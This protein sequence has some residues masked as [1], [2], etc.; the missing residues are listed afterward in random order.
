M[1]LPDQPPPKMAFPLALEYARR[2]FFIRPLAWTGEGEAHA[3]AWLHY[4]YGWP[5][6]YYWD[7]SGDFPGRPWEAGDLTRADWLAYWTALPPSCFTDADLKVCECSGDDLNLEFG[8]VTWD[9]SPNP[10]DS[11]DNPN[12]M[13]GLGDCGQPCE[14]APKPV[15]AGTN[16]SGTGSPSSGSGAAAGSGGGT[17]GGGGGGSGAPTPAGGGGAGGSGSGRRRS[18]RPRPSGLIGP[19]I[20]V[21]AIRTDPADPCVATYAERP[22]AWSLELSLSQGPHIADEIYSVRITVLGSVIGQWMLGPGMS[23]VVSYNRPLKPDSASFLAIGSGSAFGGGPA[24]VTSKA[25]LA[26]L[27]VCPAAV[28]IPDQAD[29]DGD[30]VALDVSPYF[31]DPG[32]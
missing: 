11:M 23:A 3:L 1:I 14:C 26:P 17:G 15:E 21:T 29:D 4:P 13:L 24:C 16:E 9:D 7:G 20:T 32:P 5:L 27:P 8:F 25:A 18:R 12:A 6:G 19:T 30:S 10:W 28:E 22:H 2:G 31:A